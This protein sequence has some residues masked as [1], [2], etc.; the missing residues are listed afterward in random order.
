MA[1]RNNNGKINDLEHSF[2]GISNQ[3]KMILLFLFAITA[4]C[5]WSTVESIRARLAA[6]DAEKIS[7]VMAA[8]F[9]VTSKRHEENQEYLSKRITYIENTCVENLLNKNGGNVSSNIKKD[10]K[11]EEADKEKER[12]KK[13]KEIERLCNF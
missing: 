12:E 7:A 10:A 8:E 11:Q 3:F 9:S 13:K 4:M 2:N 6:K 1:P 5:G